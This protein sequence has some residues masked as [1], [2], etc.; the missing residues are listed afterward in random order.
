[1]Y[2]RARAWNSSWGPGSATAFSP[3]W[4][5]GKGDVAT[6]HLRNSEDLGLKTTHTFENPEVPLCNIPFFN[7]PTRSVPRPCS[8][9]REDPKGG[10]VKGGVTDQ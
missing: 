7:L 2:I 1:M 8:Q 10:F 6:G 5:N 4:Q 9:A 3:A